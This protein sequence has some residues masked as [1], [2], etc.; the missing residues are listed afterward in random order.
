[1]EYPAGQ[2]QG[3]VVIGGCGLGSL[4]RTSAR[5]TPTCAYAFNHRAGRHA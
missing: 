4:A 2:R 1:M 5:W 3:Y